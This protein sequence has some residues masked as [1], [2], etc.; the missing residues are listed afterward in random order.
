MKK[1]QTTLAIPIALGFTTLPAD[2]PKE[3]LFSL[4]GDI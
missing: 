2:T 1:L 4:G 3:R